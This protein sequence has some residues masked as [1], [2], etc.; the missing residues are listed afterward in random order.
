[1]SLFFRQDDYETTYEYWREAMDP[2]LRG[3]YETMVQVLLDGSILRARRRISFEAFCS[4][5]YQY[6]SKRVPDIFSL[7]LDEW[8]SHEIEAVP[9]EIT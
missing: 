1:M 3:L 8:L 2:H 6:S 5:V 7:E 4:F 9:K